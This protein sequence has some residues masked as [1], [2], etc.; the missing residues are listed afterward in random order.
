MA[1]A[2]K[3]CTS[4]LKLFERVSATRPR[5]SKTRR[6]SADWFTNDS[7]ALFRWEKKTEGVFCD[8][9]QRIAQLGW[10]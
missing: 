9:I 1:I 3:L 8:T 7:F 10:K 4:E 5:H 6:M 2:K